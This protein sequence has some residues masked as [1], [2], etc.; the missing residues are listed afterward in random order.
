MRDVVQAIDDWLNAGEGVALAT[1]V[2]TWGSAPRGVGSKMAV[3][4]SG[5][6]AGS[7]S[8]GCV[9]GAVAE[10]AQ[11]VLAVGEP[12]LVH[13]GVADETA[14]SVGLA[15]GG[16]IDVFVAPL[17]RTAFEALKGV[18]TENRA[19]ASATVVSGPRGTLGRSLLL[20]AGGPPEGPAGDGDPLA[21]AARE[22]LAHGQCRRVAAGELDLF[23]DVLLPPPTLVVVGAV[24]I[25]LAL[26]SIARSLG[27]RTVVVDPR[28]AFGNRERFPDVDELL[29][30]WPDEALRRLK[31]HA[32]TAVAVLTHDPKIDDP[33][34]E[35]ALPSQAFYVGALGSKTT[36]EKRRKRLMAAGLTE[37]QVGRLH[38]PIGLDLGGRRPEEIALAVMAEIVAA[39]NGRDR[40]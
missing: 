16:K 21:A 26:V 38:A 37:S 27:Y 30:E 31:L 32:G 5:R 12:R 9:E 6:I 19:A 1:V 15:C 35:A 14:W 23:V 10:A 2:A 24:H 22:A 8:G 40:R 29:D 28:T 39:R 20:S 7:V 4:S 33:A 18:L 25:A 3:S 17:D 36:Q 13:F 34:L 11:Q